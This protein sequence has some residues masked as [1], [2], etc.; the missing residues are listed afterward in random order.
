MILFVVLV[1]VTLL[2]L[3][4]ATFAFSRQADVSACEVVGNQLQARL[5]AE[6]G[7][8]SV[9]LM[10]REQRLETNDW[11]N[12][13]DVFRA[14]V[15]WS[16]ASQ[17][18][19]FA[20]T[21]QKQ[22]T[23]DEGPVVPTWRFSIVADDPDDDERRV[24]YGIT[25]EA[26]KLNINAASRDQLIRLL[27]PIVPEDVQ[28]GDLA[29]AIIAWRDPKENP[30][31]DEYYHSLDP[32]YRCK[33]A[34]FETVEELL[35]VRG[36]TAEILYGED[37][38]RNGLLDANEDDGDAHFPPDDS[39]GQ[40]DQGLLPLVT[41]YSV[42]PNWANDNQRRINIAKKDA[43]LREK[44]EKYF[45]DADV[46]DFIVKAAGDPKLKSPASLLLLPGSPLTAEDLPVVMD[47]LTTFPPEAGFVGLINVNTARPAVLRCVDGLTDGEVAEIVS[48]R[49]QLDSEAKK[50]TAWLVTQGVLTPEKFAR[51]AP[52]LTARSFHFTIEAIGYADHI[53]MFRRLQV[54]VEMRG[55]VPQ[56]LYWRDLTSLGLGYPIRSEEGEPDFVTQSVG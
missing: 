23:Q 43:K 39:D 54:V 44:L 7:I 48:T 53:G 35:L 52:Q 50:T 14:V 20:P 55:Q 6:A 38:N 28:A 18:T 15:V 47:R 16:E 36:M 32:P 12:N 4:G 22:Q 27:D 2:A 49:R 9:L 11:W 17:G 31:E 1:I 46:V 10:L 21:R 3:L 19:A 51:V 30:N 25:D 45:D 5:A 24:R 42:E 29:D 34:P 8:Q 33:N 40:L 37:V 41:V 13:P 56:V 26:G